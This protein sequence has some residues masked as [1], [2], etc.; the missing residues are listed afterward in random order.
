MGGSVVWR[1]DLRETLLVG[2]GQGSSRDMNTSSS[3]FFF[4]VPLFFVFLVSSISGMPPTFSGRC[5]NLI[6]DNYLPYLH[7][8]FEIR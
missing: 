1:S 6:A 2:V 7:D 4:T 8:W 3:I 5:Y